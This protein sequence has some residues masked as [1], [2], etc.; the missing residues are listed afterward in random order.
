[1]RTA[2]VQNDPHEHADLA[3]DPGSA[4][5]LAALLTLYRA[6]VN[7]FE[8]VSTDTAGFNAAVAQRGG[9]MGPWLG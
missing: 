2:A 9:Y 5:Q 6:E 4:A 1:M 8:N 7:L 3:S